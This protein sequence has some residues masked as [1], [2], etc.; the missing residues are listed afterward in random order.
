MS[1]NE[2]LVPL[3]EMHMHAAYVSFINSEGSVVC[4]HWIDPTAEK[5]I[6]AL[7]PFALTK[8]NPA[9]PLYVCFTGQGSAHV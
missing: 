7:I 6:P 1:N 2:S 8:Q 5:T 3:D 9:H 4:A